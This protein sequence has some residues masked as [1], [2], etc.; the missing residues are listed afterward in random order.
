MRDANVTSDPRSETPPLRIL[1]LDDSPDDQE[2]VRRRLESE[3]AAARITPVQSPTEF[4]TALR[5]EPFDVILSDYTLPGYD[6]SAA[7]RLAQQYCPEVPYIFVSGT[8]GEERAIDSIKLGATDYVLKDRLDRLPVAIRRAL[9][10]VRERR[11]RREAET[12]LRESEERFRLMAE[13]IREVFWTRRVDD[14][15]L[16]YVSPAYGQIW[17]RPAAELYADP[18]A[19][20]ASINPEDRAAAESSL[21]GV[22]G[23]SPCQLEYRILRPDGSWRWIED[24]AYPVQGGDGRIERVVGVSVDI[25]ERKELETRL[26]Q[27]QKMEAIGQLAGG[28]AHDFNNV[29]TVIIGYARLLLDREGMPPAFVEP[30]SQMFTAGSRAAGLTRQLLLFSR[31]QPADRRPIDL[32]TVVDEMGAMLCRLITE[33]IGLRLEP[34]PSALVVDADAVM[35]EQVLMNLALNARDAMP[36]GGTLLIRVH[37]VEFGADEA[38]RRREARAGKFACMTVTDTGCGIAPENLSKIFEPF[39]TTKEAGRGTGLGLA[40]VYGIVKQHDGWI[41]V[42][43]TPGKG[44]TFHVFLPL[45]LRPLPDALTQPAR[46]YGGMGSSETILLIEDETA[47][48]EFAVAVLRGTGFRVLQASNGA[49]ALE[50]WKWHRTRIA[51]V[52]TDVVVPQCASGIALAERF[53]AEKPTLKV[54]LT[55]GY[56][57]AEP[58]R[59]LEQP[60][61]MRFLP[62]PYRPSALADAIRAALD[63]ATS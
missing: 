47:V 62:K 31:R 58:D 42:D 56:G 53:R 23:G 44:T 59:K 39:Y 40:T 13:N 8:I 48:R 37:S 55:S 5:G 29:L 30:I 32:N 15:A 4:E 61:G 51:L 6:G 54:V 1:H 57:A 17:G 10:E 3:W 12:A 46:L 26:L 24:R 36:E 63:D 16:V 11:R 34:S 21:R 60:L 19:W 50:T 49:E 22:S 28:L 25:T 27:A 20:F 41:E 9:H 33:T 7:L 52:F 14:F 45:S 43:S 38:R 18:Q 35:L 2:L